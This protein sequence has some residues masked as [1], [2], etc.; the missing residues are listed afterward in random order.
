M[1]QTKKRQKIGTRRLKIA[2]CCILLCGCIAF[3]VPIGSAD[4]SQTTVQPEAVNTEG[5]ISWV[6]FTVSYEAMERARNYDIET[7]ESQ[8]PI[9][10]ISVLAYLGAKYGGDFSRYRAKDMDALCTR[11]KNGERISEITA[12]IKKYYDYYYEAYS[13]VLGE[14]LG[15]YSIRTE[16][17]SGDPVWKESYGLKV[18]SPIAE[19]FYFDHYDDFCASRSY[20]YN[21]KH[22]GH[23]LMCSLGTPITAVESGVIEELGWNQYGGWRVGIRSFDKKRYYYYAHMRRN[24]PYHP[25]VQLGAVVKAGDVIGYVGRTGYS[26]E[27]N[28]NNITSTHLHWGVELIFEES[29][30][31]AS[32]Q[33]W[34]DLYEITK[35]LQK[36]RSTVWRDEES[37][38]YYR[39]YDY[40]D[41][42]LVPR[43]PGEGIAG[44]AV[45]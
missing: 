16:D 23:D 45:S 22:F 8:T 35:L 43:L 27:E 28:T 1:I 14:Y 30:K 37:K 32:T 38:E 29:Q 6:D 26:T 19:G 7:H 12:D 20:G 2:A 15:V 31:D 36:H 4:W 3:A 24:R 11:L 40:W 25:N 42:G 33:I 17:E 18:F 13:A 9:D 39:K 21:R 5:V 10:W 44:N 34:I 41:A